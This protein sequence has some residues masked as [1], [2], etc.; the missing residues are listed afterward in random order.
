MKK[1]VVAI[2]IL[3][4]AFLCGC[5]VNTSGYT[6]E[7]TSKRWLAELDGGAR[8][9][10]EF[11]DDTADLSI[12]SADLQK[13][14]SGKY[15]ADDTSFVIFVPEVARNYSFDYTPKG[16]SLELSYNGSTIKLNSI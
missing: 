6:Y 5:S 9:E 13:H 15:I 2:C 11:S 16:E 10:L 4:T 1:I 8:V 12:T 14:I 7:L 3:M